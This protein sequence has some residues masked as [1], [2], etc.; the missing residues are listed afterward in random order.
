MWCISMGRDRDTAGGDGGGR[1]GQGRSSSHDQRVFDFYWRRAETRGHTVDTGKGF[2]SME[3]TM[4]PGGELTDGK[5]R[6]GGVS[7]VVIDVGVNVCVYVCVCVRV[8]S[9]PLHT[10]M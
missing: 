3:A 6:Q 4:R 5:H 7:G 8:S 9:A 2:E 1:A 10:Y